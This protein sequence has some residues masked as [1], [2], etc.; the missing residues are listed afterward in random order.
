MVVG[1]LAGVQQ[2]VTESGLDHHDRTGSDGD[3]DHC[4]GR[5]IGAI[6]VLGAVVDSSI[7]PL[8]AGVN[9]AAR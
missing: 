3:R 8:A 5:L 2:L 7:A 9:G 1:C 6:V 4:G